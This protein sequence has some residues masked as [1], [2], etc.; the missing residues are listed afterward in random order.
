[1][2]PSF[3]K[4]FVCSQ[5]F[6]SFKKNY[7]YLHSFPSTIFFLY[8]YLLCPINLL[9]W[10]I[11]T[12]SSFSFFQAPSTLQTFS[13]LQSLLP[14]P[15]KPTSFSLFPTT[16]KPLTLSLLSAPYPPF[17][18]YSLLPP[19]LPIYLCSLL[20]ANLLNFPLLSSLPILTKSFPTTFSSYIP[21][22]S[23]YSSSILIL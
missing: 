11:Y 22:K 4:K 2:T 7:L 12:V 6:C 19:N 9:L 21:I 14:N 13:F 15:R 1:M 20:P 18:L 23:S 8:T 17:Y 3:T 16:C 10:Y 5:N